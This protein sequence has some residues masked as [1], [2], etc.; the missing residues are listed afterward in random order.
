MKFLLGLN[1]KCTQYLLLRYHRSACT[2]PDYETLFETR[3][4]KL[5]VPKRIMSTTAVLQVRDIASNSTAA[6]TKSRTMPAHETFRKAII[7]TCISFISKRE[8]VCPNFP[9]CFHHIKACRSHFDGWSRCRTT[10]P[11]FY[12]SV[13]TSSPFFPFMGQR[14]TAFHL[15]HFYTHRRLKSC[16]TMQKC[17]KCLSI[18]PEKLSRKRLGGVK[19]THQF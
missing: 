2:D 18:F 7:E 10:W 9:S 13:A 8:W 14:K 4:K 1:R 11:T 16:E 15:F 5:G 17:G 19:K 12:G 6:I 3:H